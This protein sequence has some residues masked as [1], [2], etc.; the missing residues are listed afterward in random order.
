MQPNMHP[1][2]NPKPYNFA[3]LI[4]CPNIHQTPNIIPSSP[5]A[6][7]KVDDRR[8]ITQMNDHQ[9]LR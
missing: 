5:S 7:R 9:R 1:K 6:H 8:A 3:P 4:T 2:F